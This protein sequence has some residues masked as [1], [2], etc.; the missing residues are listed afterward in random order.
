MTPAVADA[1][2]ELPFDQYQRYRLIADLA[3]RVRGVGRLDVLDV[4]GRTA[5][6]RQFLPED[7]VT[8][9]DVEPSDAEGLVLGSGDRLPFADGS[10]DLVVASDTL[11]HVPPDRREAFTRECC[12]VTRRW[13]VLAGPYHHPR[14]AEAEELL[15]AF[16]A[17]RVG[18]RHRYLEEHRE[19]GLPER[20]CVEEWCRAAG[21]REIVAVGHGNL[22]RWLGL[23][24]LALYLDADAP[25]RPAAARLHRFYNGLLYDGDRRGLL[26]RHAVVAAFGDAPMPSADEV[27]APAEVPASA[28]AP[29]GHVLAELAEFDRERDIVLDERRR[30][31]EEVARALADLHGHAERLAECEDDLAGHRGTLDA[32]RAELEEH[33]AA[34]A[35]TTA[36]L[37]GHR[38]TLGAA[39]HDLEATRLVVMD[40]ERDL[41]GHR[42][43]VAEQRAEL[44]ALRTENADA[45]RHAEEQIAAHVA[46]AESLRAQIETVR[47]EARAIEAE[48]LRK[49]RW[50]R[51]I[52]RLLRRS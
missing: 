45:R 29:L 43:V 35:A 9:V 14:I 46:E 52:R 39:R 8:L 32:T 44:E 40:L 1:L 25:L 28:L 30:L 41:A 11:E 19:L 3:G 37:A 20:A 49:T 15:Q 23:M 24:C 7:R 13:A 51:R 38:E 16:L 47:G 5:V 2:Q 31:E 33:R 36:D 22:E 12:R 4:G 26:Y 34:L 17:A 48:L 50:R 42:G 21:A 10:F 6:L 18:E 27:L